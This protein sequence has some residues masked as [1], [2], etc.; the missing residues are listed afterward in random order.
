MAERGDELSQLLHARCVGRLVHSI[1]EW[2]FRADCTLRDR[3]VGEQHEILDQAMA[4]QPD[5][6]LD[7][8]RLAALAQHYT[9]FRQIE[10][11]APAHAPCAA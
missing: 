8:R 4:L 2:H 9:G 3:F 6:P 5:H 11:E 7:I 10:I 1:D